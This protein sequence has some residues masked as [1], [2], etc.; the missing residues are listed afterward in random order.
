M[1]PVV[2]TYFL[3][4]GRCNALIDFYE[5]H[6]ENASAIFGQLKNSIT[7]NGLDMR[8]VTSYS[9]DNASVNFGCKSSV[10][11]R[12]KEENNLIIKANCNAHVVHNM[13]KHGMEQLTVDIESIVLKIFAHFP[14]SAKRRADLIE[15]CN[16]VQCEF[17]EILRHVTTRWLSLVPAIERI[18]KVYNALISY[19]RSLKDCPTAIKQL[20]KL[21]ESDV[22]VDEN[23]VDV[24]E[25]YLMFAHALTSTI[26]KTILLLEADSTTIVDV[27]KIMK[28][29]RN[30]LSSRIQQR[31]FGAQASLRLKKLKPTERETIEAEFLYVCKRMLDYLEKRFDF[32]DGNILHKFAPLS[33]EKEVTYEEL[34]QIVEALQFGELADINLDNLFEETLLLN[35]IFPSLKNLSSVEEKWVKMFSK[36]E[37]S[38]LRNV[39]R[40]VSFV[41]SIP[42]SNVFTERIFSVMTIKWSDALSKKSVDLVKSELL[43]YTNINVPCSEFYKQCHQDKKLLENAKSQEKYNF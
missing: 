18:L 28:Q 32:S 9:A 5:D 42:S 35:S 39:F 38:K 10:F 2:V 21:V 29:L 36:T 13:T 12:F 7:E 14:G 40:I 37:E 22:A 43:L 26:E 25:I 27:V 15:F 30:S 19:F 31:F 8:F 24:V 4:T 3:R 23:A 41:M 16:Y 6:E 1:F 17:Q 11:T 34:L 20:L 33:L